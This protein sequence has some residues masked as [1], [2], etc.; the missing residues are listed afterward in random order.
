MKNYSLGLVLL[1]VV[2]FTANA[3]VKFG[4]QG[5]VNLSQLSQNF[6]D[7]QDEFETK[8][9]LGLNLGVVAAY[10]LSDQLSLRSGL[11][12]TSKGTA[13]DLDEEIGGI[14]GVSVDGHLR[15]IVNYLEI[16][17]NVSYNVGPVDLV[18]GFYFAT[19]VS[20]K[21]DFDYTLTAVDG[22]GNGITETDKG[23]QDIDFNT[24]EFDPNNNNDELNRF[25]LGFN[26]G[27][28]Y[29]LS[30]VTLRLSYAKG[31]SNMTLNDPEDPDF[32]KA[33]EKLKNSTLSFGVIYFLK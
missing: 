5:G 32:D 23:S 20:A 18:G 26:L 29:A 7:P 15:Y 25:D 9:R 10:P 31:F 30:P 11:I 33:D 8:I 12:Y 17:L 6:A 27:V 24:G 28:E 2:G 1:L 19:G 3:Q 13:V 22:N 16:P 4:I 14:Q 21:E